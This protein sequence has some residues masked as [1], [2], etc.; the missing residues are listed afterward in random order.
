MEIVRSVY[1]AVQRGDAA[2]VFAAYD[3]E[4]EFDFTQS[5]IVTLMNH[6]VYIGHEGVKELFQERRADAWESVA[7][8]CEELIDAGNDQ[9][10]SVVTTKGRGRVSEAEVELVH[11]GLWTI[12]NGKVTRAAWFGSREKALEAAG[13]SE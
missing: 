7:D 12:R 11:A 5:P 3:R 13:L 1:D 6:E 2:A 9:V 8:R 10:V 4:I